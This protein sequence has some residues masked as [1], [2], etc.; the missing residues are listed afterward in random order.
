VVSKE[1]IGDRE[2]IQLPQRNT[3]SLMLRRTKKG[4]EDTRKRIDRIS[5]INKFHT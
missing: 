1:R 3:P 2:G 4:E 5:Q